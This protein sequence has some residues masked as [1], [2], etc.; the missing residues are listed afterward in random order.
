MGCCYLGAMEHTGAG[1]PAGADNLFG[2][3]IDPSCRSFDFTLLFEDAIFTTL[4]AAVFLLLVPVQLWRISK[5]KIKVN[6][7]TLATW[8]LVSRAPGFFFNHTEKKKITNEPMLQALLGTLFSLHLAFL[9]LLSQIPSFTTSLSL[10]SGVLAT[11][12]V[13]AAGALSFLEDQRSARPSDILVLYFSACTLLTIPRLRS[14]WLMPSHDA[15]KAILTVT[16]IATVAVVVVESSRKNKFLRQ[17]Y[18]KLPKEETVSFWSRGLFVW[19]LPFF[20][21]GYSKELALHDIP[22]VGFGLEG[23]A[24]WTKLQASGNRVK[25]RHWLL[26]ATF[27][28]NIVSVISGVI[29]RLALS[30]FSFAQ[31]FLI[32]TSVSNLQLRESGDRSRY[33]RALVGA[34]V[35]AYT[36]IAVCLG[37][38]LLQIR[39]C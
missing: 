38:S 2:P 12:A 3:R 24:C 36:G 14:L 22:E 15:L 6:S 28:A 16:F 1:C 23:E 39:W 20:K 27:R 33:G 31:P 9:V 10:A 19:I 34:F 26:R 37:I 4:P 25:G 11:A 5:T 13:A 35:L 32:S 17:P 30:C 21:L 29:P 7:Y 8:K 18:K